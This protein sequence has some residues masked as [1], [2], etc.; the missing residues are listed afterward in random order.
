MVEPR[1]TIQIA[2]DKSK[3]TFTFLPASG[4]TGTLEVTTDQLLHLIKTFGQ[5]YQAMNAGNE[6]PKLEGE[7][8]KAVFGP[9]WYASPELIGEASCLSFQHPAFGPLGFLIPI[10]Q[11]E[12]KLIPLLTNQVELSKQSRQR[13]AN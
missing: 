13:R 10:D 7:Q 3:A 12:E 5:T 4:V 2:E 6:I 1:M 11:V 8:I 9:T